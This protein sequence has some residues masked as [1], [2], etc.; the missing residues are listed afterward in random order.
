MV[1]VWTQPVRSVWCSFPDYRIQTLQMPIYS[2]IIFSWRHWSWWQDWHWLWCLFRDAKSAA[3]ILFV[4][5]LNWPGHMA[6]GRGAAVHVI[7]KRLIPGSSVGFHRKLNNEHFHLGASYIYSNTNNYW[8]RRT[9]SRAVFLYFVC[10]ISHKFDI[11]LRNK[12]LLWFFKRYF[13]SLSG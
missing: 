1:W 13:Y 3:S 5:L 4:V 9:S 6:F 11:Y 8:V 12:E 2:H 7:T 10:R